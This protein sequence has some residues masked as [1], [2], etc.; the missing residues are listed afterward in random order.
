MDINQCV[1]MCVCEHSFVIYPK[2]KIGV[3]GRTGCGKSTLMITLYRLIE[4][5]GGQL[6]IDQLDICSIGLQDLRSKLSLVP[7]VC[8]E[9]L[10]NAAHTHTRTGAVRAY[11]RQCAKRACDAHTHTHTHFFYATCTRA[12][13]CYAVAVL[14]V[15]QFAYFVGRVRCIGFT[16]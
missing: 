8:Q 5:C 15:R 7:Q 9:L 1:C 3:C 13:R 14:F 10:G 6:L 11:T 2:E 4:P 16:G 12:K